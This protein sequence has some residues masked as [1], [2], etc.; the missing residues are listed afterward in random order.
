MLVLGAALY[1]V[2]AITNLGIVAIDDYASL[3]RYFLPAQDHSISGIAHATGF[4]S[5]VPVVAHFA[6]ARLALA[7]GF[8]H[9]LSQ[10]RF[11]LLVL[12]LL[13]FGLM[14]W[15]GHRLFAGYEDADRRRHRTTF[16]LLLGFYFLAPVV[17]TRPMIESLAAPW[18]LVA[19]AAT[20]QYLREGERRWLVAGVVAVTI[21]ATMRPQ[22][23]VVVLALPVVIAMR[24]R[25]ADLAVFGAAALAGFMATGLID[26]A[27]VGGFH[28]SLRAYVRYN[29][30]TS[31]TFGVAPWYR[32]ILLFLGLSLPPVFL[33]RYQGLD[34]RAR[35][36]PLLPVVLMFGLFV[37]AHS[38]VP[39]KEERF[40]I[41][42]LP[43]FLVLLTP[44]AVHLL[45]TPGQRWRVALFALLNGVG[46]VVVVNSPPQQN[47]LRLAAWLDQ[48][49]GLGTVVIAQP[50]IL[51]PRAFVRHAV[52]WRTGPE[53]AD[54]VLGRPMDCATVIVSLAESGFAR[55]LAESPAHRQIA[56]FTPGVLEAAV[57]WLNPRHNARR[58]PIVVFAVEGCSD[59]E[60]KRG[61]TRG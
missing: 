48:R 46:L 11:N 37:A 40:A 12:G 23:G 27:L 26:L 1:A 21:A 35:Y 58:G 34:W 52:L 56:R 59:R 42:A 2:T 33:A 3:M 44:L 8:V 45:T 19:A 53:A 39:H 5:P 13:A 49:P 16:A 29:V 38:A 61:T 51:L 24:R 20:A 36:Q 50:N 17:F 32:F 4:R 14:A 60:W 41:P 6:L 54:S 25:W 7:L 30:S 10:L 9:P 22:A 57:V 31:S 18:V 47:V 55:R 15:A 28:Q 43:L